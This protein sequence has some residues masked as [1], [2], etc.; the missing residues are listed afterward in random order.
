[1]Q[2]IEGFDELCMFEESQHLHLLRSQSVEYQREI[3]EQKSKLSMFET[4]I[5]QLNHTLLTSQ[6]E[7]E[8]EKGL[9]EQKCE[10]LEISLSELRTKESNLIFELK[11]QRQSYISK[12]KD[13]DVDLDSK[14]QELKEKYEQ[15]QDK[16]SDLEAQLEE[17]TQSAE[18]DKQ[19]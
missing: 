19:K 1:M 11:E 6:N 14:Y 15:G 10:N 16:I 13:K 5:K 8:K 17:V 7:H 2:E 12:L 18:W 3:E 9:L 4:T